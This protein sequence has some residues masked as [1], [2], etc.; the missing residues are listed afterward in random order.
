MVHKTISLKG[1]QISKSAGYNTLQSSYQCIFTHIQRGYLAGSFKLFKTTLMIHKT[2]SLK[3]LQIGKS[4]GNN[5]IHI[6]IYLFTSKGIISRGVY[7]CTGL[8]AAHV[9][10]VP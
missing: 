3:G 8:A 4:V 6:N 10:P 2:I 7:R 5:A 9:P 1:L